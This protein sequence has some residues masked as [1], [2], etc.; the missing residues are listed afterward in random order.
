MR[1][2][3]FPTRKASKVTFVCFQLQLFS[4]MQGLKNW[5]WKQT[6]VTFEAFLV[7]NQGW[8]IKGQ[9]LRYLILYPKNI[10]R[11]IRPVYVHLK[12]DKV[13]FK[14]KPPRKKK[15]LHFFSILSS[16]RHK[17]HCWMS[18]RI[19]CLFQC[20]RNKGWAYTALYNVILRI[21]IKIADS[22]KVRFSTLPILNICFQK[23]HWLDLRLVGLI[24]ANGIDVIQPI[25]PWGC[26]T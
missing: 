20:S 25:W 14:K 7:G 22:K 19:F 3:W 2:P 16:S 13:D 26:W 21:V 4:T 15:N 9:M 8:C 24:D 12:M 6:N 18:K 1:H 11:F 23:F 5:S 10:F 17:K